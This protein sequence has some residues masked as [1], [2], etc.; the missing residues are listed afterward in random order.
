VAALTWFGHTGRALFAVMTLAFIAVCS[1]VIL[2]GAHKHSVVAV[3]QTAHSMHP[4]F[5][6]VILAFPVAM[7]LATGVEA[8]ASAI[9]ELGQLDQKGRRRFGR[10]TI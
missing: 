10:I 3:N 9:S 8:P 1:M 4:A 2:G 7:A 5:I 6:A